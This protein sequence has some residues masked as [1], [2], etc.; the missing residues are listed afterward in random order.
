MAHNQTLSWRGSQTFLH[1]FLAYKVYIVLFSTSLYFLAMGSRAKTVWRLCNLTHPIH[2]SPSLAHN[3]FNKCRPSWKR[4]CDSQKRFWT[5]AMP[6][7]S[8]WGSLLLGLMDLFSQSFVCCPTYISTACHLSKCPNVNRIVDPYKSL[9]KIHGPTPVTEFFRKKK[10]KKKENE[11]CMTNFR[12]RVVHIRDH[13]SVHSQIISL[14]FSAVCICHSTVFARFKPVV[15]CSL[16]GN[17]P[18]RWDLVMSAQLKPGTL[19]GY[20]PGLVTVALDMQW[21]I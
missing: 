21:F 4:V 3:C 13:F 16:P 6:L 20:K 15:N 17:C 5:S 7:I 18:E 14:A 1:T 12:I 2:L 19:T 10:K 9:Y 11:S 8:V